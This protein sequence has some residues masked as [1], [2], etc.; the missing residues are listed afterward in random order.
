MLVSII[1]INYNSAQHTRH[2]VESICKAVPDTLEYEIIIVD[3]ASEESD[4]LQLK[5]VRHL[6]RVRIVPSRFNGGFAMGNMLGVQYAQGRYYLFLN[7]D[8]LLQN[9]IL[10]TFF[11]YAEN[12]PEVGLLSGQLYDEHGKHS[13]SFKTFPSLAKQLLGSGFARFIG[14]SRFPGNKT[15]LANPT[16]VGVVSGSC[17]FFRRELFDRLG[18]F[19]T[20]FFL[21]CEEEDISKRV[22][23]AGAKVVSLPEAK[24]THIA[25]ASTK[26]SLAIEKEFYIS[27]VHLI[28]KHFSFLVA[29]LM[30]LLRI[31]KLFRHSF[32]SIQ[33]FKVFLFL[34]HGAPKKESIRYKQILNDRIAK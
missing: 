1:T 17:M 20:A 7:N 10:T 14:T 30:K 26:R 33:D 27:Y 5:A 4:F 25:G 16:E 31:L 3:N 18:G 12:H 6:P 32:R 15:L 23:D 8:T 22:W 11:T 13:T 21:Y 2:M 34:L 24:I 19:D 28:D 9:D 29:F